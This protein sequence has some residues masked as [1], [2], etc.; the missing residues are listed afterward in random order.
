M[1]NHYLT[2]FVL[3]AVLGLAACGND[4]K[5]DKSFETGIQ[6]NEQLSPSEESYNQATNESIDMGAYTFTA[7]SNS[8]ANVPK[9]CT[10]NYTSTAQGPTLEQAK[11]R[12]YNNL[13]N[14][15]NNSFIRLKQYNDYCDEETDVANQFTASIYDIAIEA[16]SDV[17][18]NSIHYKNQILEFVELWKKRVKHNPGDFKSDISKTWGIDVKMLA[19][20]V[21]ALQ[22]SIDRQEEYC[23]EN[24]EIMSDAEECFDTIEDE[25]NKNNDYTC[26]MN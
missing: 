16:N 22:N 4:E 18:G 7:A 3:S 21:K 5:S 13:L 15:M 10:S 20:N 19:S 17:S 8:N 1:K 14:M 23:Y 11:V 9:F 24:V 26:W 6:S 25:L 12:A 2:C